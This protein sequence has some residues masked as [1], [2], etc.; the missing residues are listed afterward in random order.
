[1]QDP[2]RQNS[3][4]TQSDVPFF[5]H[6]VLV[7][8]Y[9][10]RKKTS[11]S[12]KQKVPTAVLVKAIKTWSKPSGGNTI[13]SAPKSKHFGARL[14]Y[15]TAPQQDGVGKRI[16]GLHS[17]KSAVWCC[18]VIRATFNLEQ[19]SCW[20]YTPRIQA[21]YSQDSLFPCGPSAWYIDHQF[22]SKGL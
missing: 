10:P 3:L 2:A 16:V 14:R 8:W 18:S 22:A 15:T 5:A 17:L 19:R 6:L 12:T 20:V 13:G 11:P 4:H 9:F 7:C 21:G 1:M